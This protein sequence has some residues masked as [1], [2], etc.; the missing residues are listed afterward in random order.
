M[1]VSN[2]Y[3]SLTA[4][5]ICRGIAK[6]S[7][8]LT[9]QNFNKEKEYMKRFHFVTRNSSDIKSDLMKKARALINRREGVAKLIKYVKED[10]IADDIEKG[11]F[12]FTLVQVTLNKFQHSFVEFIY[13]DK[14]VDLCNNLD[15]DNKAI[16]NQNLLPMIMSGKFRPFFL[17]F[18]S[19]SQL[20]MAKWANINAKLMKQN[21]ALSNMNT[22]DIYKCASCGES[23]MSI[24]ELQLK[25]LDEIMDVF[26]T[27]LIC[28]RTII[29]QN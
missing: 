21:E 20:H 26:A 28:F 7:S 24:S 22:T 3:D 6:R 1:E 23:K 8:E 29:V 2:K 11:I 12:E 27:C 19:P 17:A 25:G 9:I 10:F 15:L 13:Q 16:D 5:N 18:L 14:L 4:D